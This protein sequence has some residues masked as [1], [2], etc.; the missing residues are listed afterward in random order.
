MATS[1]TTAHWDHLRWEQEHLRWSAEHMRALSI[2]RRIEAQL[3]IH[4]VEIMTHRAEM[5]AHEHAQQHGS[6]T[7]V[8]KQIASHDVGGTHHVEGARRH[9]ELMEAI[10]ALDRLLAQTPQP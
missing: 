10:F 9:T 5:A 1:E 8:R 3:Y 7:P 4:E 6:T 2:L